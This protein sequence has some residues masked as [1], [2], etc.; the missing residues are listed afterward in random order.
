MI[1]TANSE[2]R[3]NNPAAV[4]LGQEGQFE[5]ISPSGDVFHVT[6]QRGVKM[7]FTRVG[8]EARGKRGNNTWR[9]RRRD[10]TD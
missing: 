5:V 4:L 9:I 8:E 2:I 1:P 6:C 7:A 10:A 3:A